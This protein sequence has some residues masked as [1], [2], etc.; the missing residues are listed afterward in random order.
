MLVDSSCSDNRRIYEIWSRG[1]RDDKDAV[2]VFDS[3]QVAQK[4]DELGLL[5]DDSV[6]DRHRGGS[7]LRDDSVELVEDDHAG[8]HVLRSFESVSHGMLACSDVLVE[9]FRSLHANAVHS[10]FLRYRLRNKRLATSG[11]TI[12]QG[13]WSGLPTGRNF[14]WKILVK[15]LK[16]EAR[17]N[18]FSD[19]F[20]HFFHANDLVKTV[21]KSN[22]NILPR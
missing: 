19:Q 13:I 16:F 18:Q 10:E 5:I 2:D 12:E 7:S 14:N 17:F 22:K 20:L 21:S 15:A 9:E 4:P 8:L 1:D 11:R 6:G 3:V